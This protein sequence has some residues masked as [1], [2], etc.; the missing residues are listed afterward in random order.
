MKESHIEGLANHNG[1]ELGACDRKVTGE[2]MTGVRTGRVLSRENRR[3]QGADVVV[4]IG[5]QHGHA[6]NGRV[7]A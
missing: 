7:C 2:A 1:P 6:R 5:R 3:D 4:R